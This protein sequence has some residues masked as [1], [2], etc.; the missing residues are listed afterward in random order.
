MTNEEKLQAW[1]DGRCIMPIPPVCTAYWKTNDWIRFVDLHGTWHSQK[2]FCWVVRAGYL[3]PSYD[4]TF[5][6]YYHNPYTDTT[7]LNAKGFY[8]T[9]RTYSRV[10]NYKRALK[11]FVARQEQGY[12]YV[13]LSFEE[14]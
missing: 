1:N 14:I 2:S 9:K 10:D 11:S 5:I 3:F 4:E 13:N 7:E 6:A 12:E 8:Q